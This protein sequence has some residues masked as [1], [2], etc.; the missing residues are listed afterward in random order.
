MIFDI[1]I[2]SYWRDIPWLE[3]C[4]RS[5]ERHCSGFREVVVV[6]PSDS[7]PWL[8]R[9]PELR[10]SARFVT[11]PSFRDDYLG[12][13]VT[14]L[15]ADCITDADL[16]CHVDSDCIF[17]R[18][19]SPEDLA[20][21]GRPRI[22][23]RP[24]EEL[25]RDWPWSRPTEEFLGWAPT[26]DFMQ[27][28]PF[29]YPSWLYPLVREWSAVHRGVEL[30][31]WI[32]TRPARGFSEFNVLGAFAYERHRDDFV[33]VRA[34]DIGQEEATCDWHWSRGGL[35][36]ATRHQVLTA[37]EAPDRSGTPP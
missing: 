8:D 9:R 6:V 21:G 24:L 30:T 33:W 25:P 2:R 23:T 4:L 36:R 7:V 17:R 22:F 31:D 12:Q 3:L 10:S 27:C 35:S 15:H 18:P 11:C 5:I 19:T 1:V 28:P 20:P 13:Q 34:V 29:V 32:L 16:I 37:L 14:K 26:H